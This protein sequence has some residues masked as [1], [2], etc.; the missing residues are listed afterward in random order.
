PVS[1][2]FDGKLA[3]TDETPPERY[4]L[5]VDGRGAPGFGNGV[6][7]V[8]LLEQD[9]RTLMKYEG[10]LQVGGRIASV[11]QRLI[12]T[13][14]RSMIGQGL[15]SLN[16]ALKARL[17]ST[18]TGIEV[19]YV[20]PSEAQFAAAVAKDVAREMMPE[21]RTLA[22]ALLVAA[23]AFVLGFLLGRQAGRGWPCCEEE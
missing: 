2:V 20:P 21:A 7:H 11:G 23:V 5:S 22:A 13:A 12:D 15:E 10:E 1:G 6:G 17:Q 4:T 8:Q 18:E 16:S 14:S 3:V 19:E 9:G